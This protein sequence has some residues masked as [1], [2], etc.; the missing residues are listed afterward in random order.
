MSLAITVARRSLVALSLVGLAAAPALAG[1]EGRLN[2]FGHHYSVI[3]GAGVYIP[4]DSDTRTTYGRKA[5]SPIVTI[6]DFTTPAGLGISWDLG[7]ERL[8]QS[9]REAVYVHG[10]AGPRVLFA[11]NRAAVAP[12]L[13]VR[14]GAYVMEFDKGSWG[15]EPGANFEVGASL[16]RHMVVSGRYDLVRKRNGVNLSGFSARMAI[17]VF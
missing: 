13:T 6:W 14:G 4:A 17:K 7:G 15:A 3:A 11:S 12:Y 1:D 5:I 9:G 10:G 8:R 16:V 2:L